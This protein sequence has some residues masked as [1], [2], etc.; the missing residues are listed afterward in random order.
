MSMLIA[1]RDTYGT[2]GLQGVRPP[3][4]VGCV[5]KLKSLGLLGEDPTGVTTEAAASS[6]GSG[7]DLNK[8][9]QGAFGTAEAVIMQNNLSPGVY[10]QGPNGQIYY[11]QPTGNAQNILGVSQTN[12]SA[13]TG[14]AVTTSS[15]VS[16]T[17]M[18]VG[19]GI[20]AVFLFVNMGKNRGRG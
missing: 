2:Y 6:S 5:E 17:V 15:G 13:N 9:L 20:V 4:G 19:L 12:V 1:P 14:A 3:C 10:T 7:I 8:L 11:K 16:G 18:V